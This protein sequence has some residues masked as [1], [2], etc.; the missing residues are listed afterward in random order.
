M[1]TVNDHTTF[2]ER[3]VFHWI[4]TIDTL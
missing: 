1:N 3:H 4:Q 2:L